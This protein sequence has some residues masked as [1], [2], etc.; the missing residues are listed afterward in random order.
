MFNKVDRDLIKSRAKYYA[1][2]TL[3]E[4]IVQEKLEYCEQCSMEFKD[5]RGIIRAEGYFT[6]TEIGRALQKLPPE[7]NMAKKKVN[8][9]WRYR[10]QERK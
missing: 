7:P 6:D 2:E 9:Y 3:I 4:E 8:G 1:Y 10:F 5:I